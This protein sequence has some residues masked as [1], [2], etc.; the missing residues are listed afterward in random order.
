MDLAAELKR[1]AARIEDAIEL[2]MPPAGSCP[3]RLNQAMRYSMG[4][5]GKRLRP[6]MVLA[7]AELFDSAG[8]IDPL[9]AAVAV[10]C[11]HTYSLIHDDLPCMDDDDFRRGRP[12]L[13]KQFDEATAVLGGDALLTLAFQIIAHRYA[14]HAQLVGALIRDLGD[15]AGY[16]HLIAGQVMDLV[17][18]GSSDVTAE[19]LDR[20][21]AGKTGAMIAAALTIGARIGGASE[22]Q[23]GAIK[24]AGLALGMAFQIVDDV[25]DATE[26]SA[27]LGKTA[28]KDAKAGKITFVKIHGI[29]QARAIAQAYTARAMN[30][31]QA[32][33]GDNEFIVSLAAS[34]LVRRK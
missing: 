10:E 15:A 30:A 25:L 16:G 12:T 17:H 24:E 26:D 22:Q 34:M 6:V 33:P 4:A 5:G 31:F 14:P 27:T 32:L 13:H 8:R 21:H 1:R 19:I 29:G 9:P 28:G 3:D 20:I 11:V 7:A 18:E 2:Q 23:V